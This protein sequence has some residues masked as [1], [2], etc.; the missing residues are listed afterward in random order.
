MRNYNIG[1]IIEQALGH[2]THTYNLRSNLY[3]DPAVRPYWGLPAWETTNG[4]MGKIPLYNNW[5]V[6]AGWQ[7]RRA[8][9][10][11]DQQARLDALFFHTQVTAVLAQDWLRRIPSIVSL[12]ATPWQYDRMGHYYDHNPG[13]AWLEQ[14]KWALNRDCFHKASHLITWSAWAKESLVADYATPEEK[15]TVLPPGVNSKEW[16]G[17]EGQRSDTGPVKLLFVGGNLGRKGGH[18]LLEAF[19]I[20]RWQNQSQNNI[21]IELHLVTAD[22]LEEEAGVFVYNGIK[23]NSQELK[24]LYHSC[25]IFCLPTYGDALPLVLAEAGA[26][27]LPVV[28]TTVGAIPEIVRHGITGFLTPPGDV[29]ALMVAL[30]RL[31]AS[32]E[33]RQRQGEQAVA[34]IRQAHDAGRNAA[35]LLSLI[36]AVVDQER[37]KMQNGRHNS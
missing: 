24:Q 9:K 15:I 7:A 36:K 33:Q 5:T 29:D 18:L 11:M 1:F 8:I 37:A 34:Y 10:V 14:W 25:H 20:L 3:R 26:A 17:G 32:P 28:S 23:A 35:T 12:D 16:A 19:R 27:G 31:I 30:Q 6:R 22:R 21:D 2:K 13:P 4:W